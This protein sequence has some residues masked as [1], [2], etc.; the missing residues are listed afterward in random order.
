MH[1][2][3]FRNQTWI[4]RNICIVRIDI[5]DR[6]AEW[7]TRTNAF[8]TYV[9]K[10]GVIRRWPFLKGIMRQWHTKIQNNCFF[11]LHGAKVAIVSQLFA[12]SSRLRWVLLT[13]RYNRFLG[14]S[15][16]QPVVFCVSASAYSLFHELYAEP[17]THFKTRNE[18]N[19]PPH[20]YL[21][22]LQAWLPI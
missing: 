19:E 9:A 20:V 18:Y 3:L 2:F 15:E 22:I 1:F 21:S 16:T 4:Y 11:H 7:P 17:I 6:M 13:S 5:N 10:P 14:L 8:R 12:P